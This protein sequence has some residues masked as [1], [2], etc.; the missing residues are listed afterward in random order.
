MIDDGT[1]NVGAILTYSRRSAKGRVP[2]NQWCYLTKSWDLL[3]LKTN[4]KLKDKSYG[5]G[6]FELVRF[7]CGG[8]L[9]KIFLAKVPPLW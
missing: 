3:I 4:L 5:C 8:E 2:T 6:Y 7:P 9:S 1:G